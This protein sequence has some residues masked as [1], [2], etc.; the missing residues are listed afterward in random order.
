MSF[1]QLLTGGEELRASSAAW[2][3]RSLTSNYNPRQLVR[4]RQPIRRLH[5]FHRSVTLAAPEAMVRRP[6]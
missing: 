6:T 4:C 2:S 3:K 5:R 1:A